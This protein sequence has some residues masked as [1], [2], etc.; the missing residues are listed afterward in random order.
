MRRRG[1]LEGMDS[2]LNIVYKIFLS[3]IFLSIGLEA[4]EIT[5]SAK[6]LYKNPTNESIDKILHRVTIPMDTSYQKLLKIEVEG[7]KKYKIKK[8]KHG[9]GKYIEFAFALPKKS[10]LNKQVNFVVQISPKVFSLQNS[11]SFNNYNLNGQYLNPSKRI[12][13]DS[14]EVLQIINKIKKIKTT[15]MRLQTILEY[16]S[17][18]LKYTVQPTTSALI[19]LK[20]KRGDCTEYSFLFVA[21][22]RAI[23]IPSRQ[24]TV[25]H[26][27]KNNTF[28]LPNHHIAEIFTDKYGW[29]PMYPNL[30]QGKNK[31]NFSLGKVSDN[32]LMYKNS[33]WT[34]SNKFP[35][36]MKIDFKEIETK[37][38]WKI[39]YKVEK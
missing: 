18:I 1:S 10:M 14:N 5:L 37:T 34:W 13:S 12:E 36:N 21:L 23:G 15:Y 33:G 19:A 8:H 17:K 39:K 4:R 24:A 25:F 31:N 3:L 9:K 28:N 27:S 11:I 29:I 6:V 35:K 30:Y 2:I 38:T 20:T 26:F 22:A 32:I 16:P 7:I